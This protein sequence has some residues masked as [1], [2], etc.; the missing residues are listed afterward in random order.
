MG[1][2]QDDILTPKDDILLGKDFQV[3]N[4]DFFTAF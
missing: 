3:K 4:Y 2:L 1:S